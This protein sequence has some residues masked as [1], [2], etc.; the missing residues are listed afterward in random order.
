M[1]LIDN[2]GIVYLNDS[3]G[4]A[5]EVARMKFGEY[6][7]PIEAT[8]PEITYIEIDN[9]VQFVTDVFYFKKDEEGMVFNC[10]RT[11]ETTMRLLEIYMTNIQDEHCTP[12]QLLTNVIQKFFLEK[13][14]YQIPD[15]VFAKYER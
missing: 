8:T 14:G 2:K 9:P 13:M 3:D 5:V 1:G 12:E 4:K 15:V 10:L 7:D 11:D 6:F